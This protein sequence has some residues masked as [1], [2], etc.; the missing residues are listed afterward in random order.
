MSGM[1]KERPR[2]TDHADHRQE[3]CR[4]APATRRGLHDAR[5]PAVASD[6]RLA[7][8]RTS[9]PTASRQTFKLVGSKLVDLGSRPAQ[10]RSCRVFDSAPTAIG[11]LRDACLIQRGRRSPILRV[12]TTSSRSSSGLGA[13][14][15]LCCRSHRKLSKQCHR[16]A[17][18]ANE[19]E[20][21][22]VAGIRHGQAPLLTSSR[23]ASNLGHDLGALPPVIT[24][25]LVKRRGR[26]LCD[27]L[28]DR[29]HRQQFEQRRNLFRRQDLAVDASRIQLVG[30]PIATAITASPRPL[31]A[32]VGPS[33]SVPPSPSAGQHVLA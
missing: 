23:W 1:S 8:I 12:P 24:P 3:A 15:R 26:P 2:S 29:L 5:P 4:A 22:V 18:A 28:V 19:D 32:R 25:H 20:S 16:D 27:P 6:R 14:T 7:P 9:V 10:G 31:H 30:P 17:S 21:D 11:G 13:S 33:T